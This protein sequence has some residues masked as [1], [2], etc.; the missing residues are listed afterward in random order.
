MNLRSLAA[1]VADAFRNP[2][3]ALRIPTS[4]LPSIAPPQEPRNISSFATIQSIQNAVRTAESGDPT[5]LF[6]FYRDALL[7]DDHVQ[8]ELSKRKLS[9]IGQPLA[10]LPADKASEDDIRAAAACTR[11]IADCENWNPG[12]ANI[13]GAS[14]WPVAV[15]ENIFRPADPFPVTYDLPGT[16]TTQHTQHAP[17][18]SFPLQYTLKRLEPVSPMLFCF[19]HAYMTAL[20]SRLSTLDSWEPLLRLWPVDSQGRIN[21]D[22]TRSIPL[23]PDRHIVHRG[24]LLTDQRDNWGG[25][26]R[27]I[28]AWWL[29]RGLGRDWFAGFIERFR[30]PIP[31]AKT[32]VNDAQAVNALKDAFSACVKLGGLVIGQDDEIKFEEAQV[33]GGAEGHKIWHD[34]CNDAISKHITGYASSDKPGGLN[35][36]E[37]TAQENVRSDIRIFDGKMLSDTLEK[38]LF[39]RI[40]KFNGLPGRIQVQIGGLSPKDAAE[41]ATLLKTTSES[42]W[43]PT[44]DAIP[45]LEEKLGLS[46]QRKSTPSPQ[47]PFSPPSPPSPSPKD[48]EDIETLSV[49]RHGQL[50]MFTAG[51]GP[52]THHAPRTTP[53]DHIYASRLAALTSAY[54]GS[55][56]PFRAAILASDSRED[57]LKRLHILYA[58]WSPAR[59]AH[60]L[61]QALQLCA[62]TAASREGERPREPKP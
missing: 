62:A 9:V 32:N 12:L 3:S 50:I 19:K 29:L 21:A 20:D 5:D 52:N 24:H 34:V 56:A 39:P 46:I 10:V 42:G 37:S 6:R 58:D 49:H 27:A 60:E 54:A 26:M 35:T 25:P 53:L 15:A 14:Q 43:E 51:S 22:P 13:L 7:G 61:D 59:L 30:W 33:A 57:C 23:D 55:M 41:F 2:Q 45:V 16:R 1:A 28:L 17:R 38:Q 44:D 47:S 11:A 48:D 4:R 36:G 31:I 8:G 40:L 18:N